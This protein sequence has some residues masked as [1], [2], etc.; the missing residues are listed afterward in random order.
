MQRLTYAVSDLDGRKIF[1]SVETAGVSLTPGETRLPFILKASMLD[2]PA[3]QARTVLLSGLVFA[4]ALMLAAGVA[5]YRVTTR[6]IA[7]AHQQS[8]FVSAVSH[9]FRT[10]LTSMRHLTELLASR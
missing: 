6:E 8:D 10:P 7:L 9:E 2:A 3:S 1:G 5:L 4:A